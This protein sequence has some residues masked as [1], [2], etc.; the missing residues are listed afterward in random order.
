MNE[1]P[2]VLQLYKKN[3]IQNCIAGENG[4]IYDKQEFLDDYYWTIV[5]EL[6]GALR[7]VCPFLSTMEASEKVAC[8]LVIPMILAIIHATS[9]E[10]PILCY[11]YD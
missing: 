6:Y 5:S 2:S 9:K 3:P 8:S 7:P 1:F 10:E 4:K 11:S